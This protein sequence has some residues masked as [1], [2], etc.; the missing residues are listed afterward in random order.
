MG[1]K[2]E[3]A[4]LTAAAKK[5]AQAIH[6]YAKKNRWSSDGY[7]LYMIVDTS[8]YTL[9]VMVWAEALK[10]L[11]EEE[12][13]AIY[14]DITDEITRQLPRKQRPFNYI[15]LF[16]TGDQE[17]AAERSEDLSPSE[18]EVDEDL[19]NPRKVPGEPSRPELKA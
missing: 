10:G 5:A 6:D 3:K 16:I 9:R 18:F 7:H 8:I 14:D 12:L 15:G 2:A 1:E 11:S 17:Y 13:Q 4:I 19:I